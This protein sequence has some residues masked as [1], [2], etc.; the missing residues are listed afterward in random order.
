[1]LDFR[2]VG[3]VI[4]LLVTALGAAMLFPLALDLAAGNGHWPAFLE[5]AAI[6]AV[7]GAAL[8]LACAN[9]AGQALTLQQSFLLTA[10]TW[11]ALPFFG[12]LPFMLGATDLNLTDAMFESMSGMTTTGTTVLVGLDS[13]PV[14]LN[15]WRG[16]LQWLGGLGIVI[17]ALIFLPVMKVGGMQ[18][19]RSEGFDTLGKILPRALDISIW[20]IQIYIALTIGCIAVFMA[21]GMS[22]L[23]AVVHA[24]A[25]VSTGG[26]SNRDASFT[27]F[28]PA[29][30]LACAVFMV[31]GALPFVR[32]IQ[33]MQGSVRPLWQ[34]VQ[35]RAFLRWIAYAYAAILAYR[36]GVRGEAADEIAVTALFNL[37]SFFTGTGFSSGDILAWGPFPFVVLIAVGFIG[38]C[39]SS[40]GC[41]VKVF[42][43][44]VMFGV[45]RAR[46]A[47]LLSPHSLVRVRYGGRPLDDDVVASV[48]L[49]F[50][51]FVLS[52]GVLAVG[53]ATTGLSLRASLTGAWTAIA[54]IGPVFGPE[55]G[56]T[57]ALGDFSGTAKWIMIFGMLVGRLELLAVYVLFLPRFWLR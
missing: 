43:Y 23:D 10:A 9:G 45:I 57:G 55:V 15:L 37:V 35:V 41:S 7:A 3:Y 48:I 14:G 4:G 2:P 28:G 42:R 20:L 39:T 21:L 12:C 25:A 53:L 24:L 31:L 27:D 17:V 56:P 22:G 8:A 52:Y 16:I 19:F 50:T 44:L 46:V 49:F 30:H 54:N 1:M 34:D 29:L 26:F 47:R 5:S 40:T 11:V 33:V 13:L 32:F 18:F 36:V 51:L 38:G 6:T